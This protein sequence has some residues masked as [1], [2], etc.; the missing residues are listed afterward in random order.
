MLY[1]VRVNFALAQLGVN[2]RVFNGDFRR[3]IQVVGQLDGCTPQEV[4]LHLASQL[5]LRYRIGMDPGIAERWVAK[6]K[7][8]REREEV[9][10]ATM[11]LGWYNL[12]YRDIPGW[13]D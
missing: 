11:E 6:G 4:A 2:P 3:S 9:V 12:I 8:R 10:R 1:A 5:G 7:L 13:Q